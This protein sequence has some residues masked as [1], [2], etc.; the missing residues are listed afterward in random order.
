MDPAGMHRSWVRFV[1]RCSE[2]E[3]G[4]YYLPVPCGIRLSEAFFMLGTRR[5]ML[6]SSS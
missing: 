2:F 1:A 4:R 3:H 6:Y 5:M